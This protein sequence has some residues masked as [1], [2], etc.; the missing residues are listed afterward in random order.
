MPKFEAFDKCAVHCCRTFT[1]FQVYACQYFRDWLCFEVDSLIL[2]LNG[3]LDN[4]K[5]KSQL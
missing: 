5:K 1:Q 3:F 2:A 4:K